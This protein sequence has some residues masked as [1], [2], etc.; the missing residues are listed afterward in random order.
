MEENSYNTET[1]I[2][3]FINKN[4]LSASLPNYIYL[5]S[6]SFHLIRLSNGLERYISSQKEMAPINTIILVG[7]ED[8]YKIN[9]HVKLP[10]YTKLMFYD[11]YDFFLSTF[12]K[13]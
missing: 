3:E 5:I 11:I 4:Y 8:I 10:K 6:S 12:L 13:R 7:S 2:K 1:N 9:E